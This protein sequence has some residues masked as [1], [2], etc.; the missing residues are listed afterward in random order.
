MT[1][2]HI[3]SNSNYRQAEMVSSVDPIYYAVA[4]PEV[5][6]MIG[7]ELPLETGKGRDRP[8]ATH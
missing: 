8:D 7:Q 6:R 3:D 2:K 4:E 5:L 1:I